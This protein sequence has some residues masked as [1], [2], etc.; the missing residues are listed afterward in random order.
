ME[1]IEERISGAKLTARDRKVLD[2]MMKNKETACFM[3][4]AEIAELLEV[5]AS[6]V[7][8]L[9]GKLRRAVW[10]RRAS[11]SPTSASRSMRISPTAR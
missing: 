1:R 2:Y 3:A 9:S 8:R 10:K 11:P 4:A 6:C 7:V 5:S